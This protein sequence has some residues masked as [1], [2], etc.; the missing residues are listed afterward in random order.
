MDS[1]LIVTLV[2][3]IVLVLINITL[4]AYSYGILKGKVDSNSQRLDLIENILNNKTG[5]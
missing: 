5:R 1:A 2:S 4:V 3:V